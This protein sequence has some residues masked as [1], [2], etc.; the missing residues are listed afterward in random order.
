M[1]K[2]SRT[3]SAPIFPTLPNSEYQDRY[4]RI[5]EIMN[6]S[7]IDLLV[8]TEQENVEYTSGYLSSHWFMHGI[9]PG[10]VLFPSQGE[11]ILVVPRFWLG[12]AQKK[13]W[14]QEIIAHS[15][16]HSNPDS[17]SELLVEIIKDR[18]WDRGI[19]GYE[20]GE[21]L[22]L[23]LPIQQFDAIRQE[24]SNA[25]WAP[26]GQV[27]WDARTIKSPTETKLLSESAAG[28][29]RAITKVFN[30]IHEGINE[31]EIGQLIRKFQIEEG[32]EDR[33][34][35]NVRCGPQRYSMTDTLP[36]D[37]H[38]QEGEI[39]ILDVG[40]HRNG[41]WS[42][43][44]RC[45]SVGKP[46]SEY[47]ETYTVIIEAQ[48]AALETVHD[49]AP[50]SAPF[51]AARTVIDQSGFGVHIDMMGHGIG[52]SMYEPPMLSGIAEGEL[53]AGMVL[54]VEPWITLPNDRG[55]LCFEETIEVTKDGFQKL[56]SWDSPDLWILD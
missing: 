34:F 47:L 41:Y 14:I 19:I 32:C 55:V 49:G 35:L 9:I 37:R 8:I 39:L 26:C 36:E 4:L 31:L 45:V 11:P 24:L 20:A 48:K 2:S 42:D 1:Y 21:E 33:Q 25:T 40:M 52:M 53:Q 22:T 5:R 27:I 3:V 44:A 18:G 54:C 30:S 51:N 56:T 28:T 38:I 17:F 7:G 10:V 43:T 29:C 6:E 16:T 12:T 46:N 50:A 15:N 13:S 23:G